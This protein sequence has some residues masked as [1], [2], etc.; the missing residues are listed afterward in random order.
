MYPRDL[1]DAER[2]KREPVFRVDDRRGGRPLKESKR[3]KIQILNF[4]FS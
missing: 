4:K 2:E 1:S 3:Q